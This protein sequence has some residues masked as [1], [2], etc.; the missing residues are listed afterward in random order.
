MAVDRYRSNGG[1]AWEWT[2]P[3]MT[4]VTC[5]TDCSGRKCGIVARVAPCVDNTVPEGL[6]RADGRDLA[7]ISCSSCLTTVCPR[8]N[9]GGFRD[10][11]YASVFCCILPSEGSRASWDA[12]SCTSGAI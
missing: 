9:A 5:C 4:E 3:G 2:K 8:S 6:M 11:L 1:P 12:D 10:R 7:R